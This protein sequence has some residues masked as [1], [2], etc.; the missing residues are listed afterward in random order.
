[1]KYWKN[2][3][4]SKKK[5]GKQTSGNSQAKILFSDNKSE[6]LQYFENKGSLS[7]SSSK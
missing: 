5:K 4:S 2:Q 1:M 6:D 3:N 7:K